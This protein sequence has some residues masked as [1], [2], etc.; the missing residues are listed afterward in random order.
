MAPHVAELRKRTEPLTES[1]SLTWSS[2]AW[3]RPSR[4]PRSAPKQRTRLA[5]FT[6][7]RV[8]GGGGQRRRERPAF[9]DRAGR[10]EPKDDPHQPRLAQAYLARHPALSLGHAPRGFV[11]SHSTK[12]EFLLRK[13]CAG[14]SA[15]AYPA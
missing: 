10:D 8:V 14:G 6:F 13:T 15:V 12:A 2:A 3:A 7:A 9:P 5:G 11:K 4:A 1:R